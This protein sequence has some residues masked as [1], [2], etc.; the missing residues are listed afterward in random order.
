MHWMPGRSLHCKHQHVTHNI[1]NRIVDQRFQVACMA[2]VNPAPTMTSETRAPLNAV[3]SSVSG[4]SLHSSSHPLK[5]PEADGYS[6]MSSVFAACT[7]S[8]MLTGLC[9]SQQAYHTDL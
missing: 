7:S 1:C 6:V 8:Q 5:A 3:M 9:V 4:N 2:N